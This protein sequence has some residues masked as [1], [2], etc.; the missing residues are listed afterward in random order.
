MPPGFPLEPLS[1]QCADALRP[2][3]LS[4]AL[5]EEGCNEAMS[6]TSISCDAVFKLQIAPLS[7]IAGSFVWQCG[8]TTLAA[9]ANLQSAFDCQAGWMH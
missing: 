5:Q 9:A 1:Q 2:R 8:E 6:R 7:V 3:P 4:A